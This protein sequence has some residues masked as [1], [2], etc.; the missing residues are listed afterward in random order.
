MRDTRIPVCMCVCKFH[1]VQY[2]TLFSSDTVR[3]DIPFVY[4]IC[5]MLYI[6]IFEIIFILKVR[7]LFSHMLHKLKMCRVTVNFP[8]ERLCAMWLVFITSVFQMFA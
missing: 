2:L 4:F 3:N 5:I 8:Q 7:N 6:E 1:L